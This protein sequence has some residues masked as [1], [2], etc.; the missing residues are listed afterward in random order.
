VP[1]P[2]PFE[3]TVTGTH[4]QRWSAIG[5]LPPDPAATIERSLGDGRWLGPHDDM[6]H[7]KKVALAVAG[8]D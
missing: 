3:W 6:N 7:A 5:V 1:F 4:G 2:C 8:I